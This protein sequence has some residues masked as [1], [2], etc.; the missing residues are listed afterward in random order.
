MEEKKQPYYWQYLN[1]ILQA[2]TSAGKAV[3]SGLQDLPPDDQIARLAL[4]AVTVNQLADAFPKTCD[5]IKELD[6]I[7]D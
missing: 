4:Y 6:R 1:D 3:V 2:M 7:T 5:I